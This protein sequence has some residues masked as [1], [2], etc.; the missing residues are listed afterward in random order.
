VTT[1]ETTKIE[2]GECG[3]PLSP[4]PSQVRVECTHCHTVNEIAS[5]GAVRVA[6]KLEQHGIRVPENPMTLDQIHEHFDA[7]EAER[8]EKMKTQ[9]IVIGVLVALAVIVGLGILLSGP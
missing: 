2:C 4:G 9:A 1:A 5:V 8:R 3:A 6:K 7:V